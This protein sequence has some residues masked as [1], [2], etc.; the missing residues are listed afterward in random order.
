MEPTKQE[1][2]AARKA[3]HAEAKA[4]RRQA[5]NE[6]GTA[7]KLAVA[8]KKAELLAKVEQLKNN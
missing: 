3:L 2:R 7:T 1:L 8:A 4:A 5:L 6:K